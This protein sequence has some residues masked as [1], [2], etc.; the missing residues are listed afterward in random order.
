MLDL[1]HLLRLETEVHRQLDARINPEL[2]F[3]ISV[4]HVNVSASLLA[5][6]EVEA[7]PLRSKNRWTHK[8]QLN[9]SRLIGVS[10]SKQPYDA[11]RSDS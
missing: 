8:A 4:L 3:T 9:A 6:E 2:R 11:D 1:G 7:K 5:G 10:D